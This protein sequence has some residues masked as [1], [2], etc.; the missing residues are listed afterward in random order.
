MD[1]TLL[2]HEATFEDELQEEAIDKKHSTT[3]EAISSGI[4]MN[5]S[6]TMLNHFSQRY[7]K[8]PVFS[9]QFTKHTGIAF[10]HMRVRFDI[11]ECLIILYISNQ[12]IRAQHFYDIQSG[13]S[14][15][16]WDVMA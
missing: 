4:E 8:I 6:F 9:E 2:I 13:I 14:N 3:T 1:A 10:D 15:S 16:I 12:P 7:P 11:K 5:A